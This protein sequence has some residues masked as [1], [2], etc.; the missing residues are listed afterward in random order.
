MINPSLSVVQTVPFRRRKLAPALSSPP[1]QTRPSKSG[2]ANHLKPTGTS[3]SRRPAP[4]VTRSIMLLLTIVLPIA[5]IGRPGRPVGEQ[6]L[7]GDR[8]IV[9]RVHQPGGCRHDAMAIGVGVVA[10]RD[11]KPILE[12]HQSGHRVRARAVHADLAVVV[13]RH[14]AER[15]IDRRIHDRDL[16]AVAR[17]DRLPVGQ[18]RTAERIDADRHAR[19]ANG[20]HVDDLVQIVDVGTHEIF[21]MG[22][23]CLERGRERHALDVAVASHEQLVGSVLDPARDVGVGGAAVRRVVFEAAIL[24]R[25]VRRRDHDPVGQVRGASVIAHENR[26]GDDRRRREPAVALDDRIDVVAGQHFEGGILRQRRQR[27]RVLA[28]VERAVDR[29]AARGSR[30]SPA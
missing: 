25:V 10:D 27:V 20:V 2:C 28:H 12:R 7:D 16:Q 6:I 18:R 5:A 14:E 11:L 15:R 24:G 23:R 26:A 13:E 29:L 19:I 30:R 3:A 22:R 8:Q 21:L 1:K 17:G 9:I 4:S